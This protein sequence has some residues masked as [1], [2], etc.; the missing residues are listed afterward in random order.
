MNYCMTWS[1]HIGYIYRWL[2]PWRQVASLIERAVKHMSNSWWSSVQYLLKAGQFSITMEQLRMAGHENFQMQIQT[3][4]LLL[5]TELDL[6]REILRETFETWKL[7]VIKVI[8]Q[9]WQ[10]DIAEVCHSPSSYT[11]PLNVTLLETGER[12]RYQGWLMHDMGN[13][14]TRSKFRFYRDPYF[15]DKINI[16]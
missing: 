11:T 5:F 9:Q 16:T 13:W 8:V 7:R 3:R 14:N 15:S 2:Y 1:D 4:C 6:C 10:R 12:S